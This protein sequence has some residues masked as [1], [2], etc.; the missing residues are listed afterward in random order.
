VLVRVGADVEAGY[1]EEGR[2]EV[3]ED[4]LVSEDEVFGWSVEGE[5]R[6]EG[7]EGQVRAEGFCNGPSLAT[8]QS[9]G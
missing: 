3:G 8:L 1:D 7:A 9:K 2:D 4:S 6:E 5:L